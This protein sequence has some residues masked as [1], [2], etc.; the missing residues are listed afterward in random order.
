MYSMVLR[1]NGR[2]FNY[3]FA[4]KTSL[5][6]VVGTKEKLQN[7]VAEFERVCERRWLEMNAAKGKAMRCNTDGG[8]GGV[9]IILDNERLENMRKFHYLGIDT[10][11]MEY[12]DT[13]VSQ[14]V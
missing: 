14:W 12:V 4:F 8:L 10:A 11:A 9:E 6:I 5:F 3:T 2:Q 7:L 13:E 1:E